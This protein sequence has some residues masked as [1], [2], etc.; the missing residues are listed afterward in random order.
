MAVRFVPV[1]TSA[2]GMSVIGGPT[3]LGSGGSDLV[4]I[5]SIGFQFFLDFNDKIGNDPLPQFG[6]GAGDGV[7]YFGCGINFGIERSVRFP[8]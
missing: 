1:V 6:C 4:N 8:A 2:P 5:N 3:R 7:Q